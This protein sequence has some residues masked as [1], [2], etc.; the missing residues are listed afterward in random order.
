MSK[1]TKTILI[2]I[3]TL[4]I[5]PA[6]WGVIKRNWFKQTEVKINESESGI[7]VAL[8]KR[9]NTLKKLVDA[10]KGY[11]K[12]EKTVQTE[13]VKL[14]QPAKS[15][16]LINKAAFADKLTTAA[17]NL[18]VAVENYPEL[19]AN[20]TVVKL[21]QSIQETE[22]NLQAA[23]RIYNSNVN[24]YNKEVVSFPSNV[25]ASMILASKKKFFEA[26]ES[27]RRDVETSLD[28]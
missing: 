23:R 14:R 20:T 19:K 4:L 10:T 21:Q 25:I 26:E 13:I 3:G 8:T 27:K 7:D 28:Y 17:G 6:I 22:D 18:N 1:N 24:L 2:V 9:Y 12:H 5:L 16:S 11:M 15:D